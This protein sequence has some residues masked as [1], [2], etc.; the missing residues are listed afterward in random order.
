MTDSELLINETVDGIAGTPA[1]TAAAPPRRTTAKAVKRNKTDGYIWGIYCTL[2]LVSIIEGYSASSTDVHNENVYGP[3]WGQLRFLAIGFVLMFLCQ[4]IHYKFYRKLALPAA[5]VCLG[6]VVYASHSGV[7]INEAMRAIRIGSFTL[8]PA[9]MLKLALVMLLAKILAKNQMSGGVSTRGVVY[10]AI[11]VGVMA[12]SVYSNG[13]TNMALMMVVSVSMLI[14][15]GT[16]WKKIGV[17]LV[18]YTLLAGATYVWK[19]SRPSES[20][21]DKVNVEAQETTVRPGGY[22]YGLTPRAEN[23]EKK[24]DRS[25]MREGRIAMWIKGVKPGDKVTDANYQ[26]K[27][28]HYAMAHGGIKGNVPGNSRESAR[29]PLAYSDYI[30]SIIV[31]D[32]GLIGGLILLLVY[33]LLVVR[34]GIVASKCYRAFPALLIMGCAVMIVAQ[35]VVHMGIVTGVFP[36]S[37]QPLPLVSRGGTSIIVMSLAFGMMLSVS[38]FAVR[39]NTTDKNAVKSELKILPE[40]IR[41]ENPLQFSK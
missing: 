35:A 14:I 37:G 26:V 30:Y 28:A 1:E 31:E 27:H 15:G 3:L 4:K 13:A 17:L 18:A 32:T 25:K 29:L 22:D 21:F 20:E 6:L 24:V 16:Q 2:V 36:V 23:S 33:I 10:C 19:E 39:T 38:R 41:A 34:A 12:V 5:A 8:Q 40:D 9:E 11:V 7:M